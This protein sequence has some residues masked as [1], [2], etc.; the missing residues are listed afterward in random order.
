MANDAIR[1]YE[2]SEH[3]MIGR[4]QTGRPDK[5]TLVNIDLPRKNVVS[6][7]RTR[8]AVDV[9]TGRIAPAVEPLQVPAHIGVPHALVTFGQ[10]RAERQVAILVKE[11]VAVQTVFG[12][13]PAES[14]VEALGRNVSRKLSQVPGR[15]SHASSQLAKSVVRQ[16]G[17][18]ALVTHDRQL[19][20]AR[21]GAQVAELHAR[22]CATVSARLASVFEIGKIPESFVGRTASPLAR[23]SV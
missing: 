18:I 22:D 15:R 3:V 11:Q 17:R 12:R 14:H 16:S 4:V 10:A 2:E 7:C 21:L 5:V 23:R 9:S 1:R 13:V 20:S 8:G 6:R 19:A